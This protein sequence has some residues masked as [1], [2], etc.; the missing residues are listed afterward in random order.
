MIK[1]D[2]NGIEIPI[3]IKKSSAFSAIFMNFRINR[4]FTTCWRCFGFDDR[5]L[6]SFAADFD[7]MTLL[8]K[9]AI[10]NMLKK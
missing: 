5:A 8:R 10:G 9:I 2:P 1:L 3:L 4:F 7:G 6:F